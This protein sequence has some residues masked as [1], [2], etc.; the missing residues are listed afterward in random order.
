MTVAGSSDKRCPHGIRHPH[1]CRECEDAPL[2]SKDVVAP[3]PW[4]LW[5]VG[6]RSE[7]P[8]IADANGRV[9][10]RAEG[11]IWT[12][13]EFI[14]PVILAAVNGATDETCEQRIALE[15]PQSRSL[16]DMADN[17]IREMRKHD[18]WGMRS[19]YSNWTL[20]ITRNEPTLTKSDEHSPCSIANMWQCGSCRTLNPLLSLA[21]QGCKTPRGELKASI[22][23]NLVPAAAESI[24]PTS[25]HSVGPSKAGTTA[26]VETRARRCGWFGEG[27][28][29]CLL[30]EGHETHIQTRHHVCE[31]DGRLLDVALTGLAAVREAERRSEKANAGYPEATPPPGG[32]PKAACPH[33]HLEGKSLAA[34]VWVEV[35]DCGKIRYSENGG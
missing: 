33:K 9:I 4:R 11:N 32:W 13:Q 34:G 31:Q 27:R 2:P 35:C 15:T 24:G 14:A 19:E 16:F 5:K 25:Y 10:A 18:M 23:T 7:I 3:R 1:P 6:E 26:A 28:G 21:C 20:R 30:N 29:Q 12:W 8:H 22:E 17:L